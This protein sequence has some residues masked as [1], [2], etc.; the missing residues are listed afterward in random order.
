MNGFFNAFE[1]LSAS[2]TDTGAKQVLLQRADTLANKINVTDARLASL[3]SDLTAEVQTGTNTANSLLSQIASLN[4]QIAQFEIGAPE[5][6]LSLRDQRQARLEDLAKFMD[7]STRQIPGSNGQIQIVAKDT[8]GADVVLVDRT[9]ARGIAFDG[10]Q[11]TAGTPAVPLGLQGGSLKGQL[12]AR[13]GVVQQLRDDLKA[14][15]DQLTTA[16]NTAYSPTGANFFETPPATGLIKLEPGLNFSTLRTSATGDAGANEVALAVADVARARFSTG[17]GDLIDGTLGGFFTKTVSGLGESLSSINGK[18]GDQ[19]IVQDMVARKRDS[20]SA[21]S[22]DEE[23]TD[24]MK[25][26]RAYQASARV[27]RVMDE[28]LDGLVNN[29]LR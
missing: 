29:M 25:F 20:V 10:T 8:G 28:L 27:V 11:I 21:V 9:V 17:G 15:A 6:A 24:L 22:M 26:Q 13:D 14:T 23:M 7:F 19:Q 16:V 18:L 12:L 3:Q 4:G 2:P 1:N 5:S